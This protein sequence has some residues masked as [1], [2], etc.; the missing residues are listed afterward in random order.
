MN[1]EQ[2][3]NEQLKEAIKSGDK[4]RLETIRSIRA[5]I[6]EFNKSGLNREM[7]ADD[8]LKILQTA[9]KRRKDAIELYIK[10][11]RNDLADKE[12]L[13]LG[14]I[15]EFLPAQMSEEDIITVVDQ[16]IRQSDAKGIQDL[17]K[18]MGPAMKELKGK[19]DGALVQKI[20]KSR[21]ENL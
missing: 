15:T 7:N 5:S 16:L 1:L 20:V 14:I 12:K 17:G 19:A 3:I 8:E 11:N 18:I 21:L 2:T 9:A 13:E 6:I 10:G 4:L